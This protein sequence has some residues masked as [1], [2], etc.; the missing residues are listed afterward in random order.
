MTVLTNCAEIAIIALITTLAV[1][2]NFDGLKRM[3]R[4][5]CPFTNTKQIKERER[6]T[7]Y[8]SI[9]QALFLREKVRIVR[10]CYVT[11]KFTYVGKKLLFFK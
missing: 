2:M 10:M 1:Q 8:T 9:I 11:S 4:V 6:L 5:S 7:S 3:S